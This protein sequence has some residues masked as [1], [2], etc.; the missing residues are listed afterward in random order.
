MEVEGSVGT[1]SGVGHWSM[2]ERKVPGDACY[3]S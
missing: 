2:L 3:Y 1:T